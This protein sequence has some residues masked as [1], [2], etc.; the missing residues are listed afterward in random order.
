MKQDTI[1]T[2]RG[3]KKQD[4]VDTTGRLL[5]LVGSRPPRLDRRKTKI[6]D[7]DR[8]V[9]VQENVVALEV[10]VDNVL[11]VQ[12]AAEERNSKQINK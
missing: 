7:F 5:E 12:I 9:V 2:S 3:G 1:S 4:T 10:A 8:Q 11:G 6:A